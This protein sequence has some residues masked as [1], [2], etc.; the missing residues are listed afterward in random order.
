M[1]GPGAG[2]DLAQRYDDGVDSFDMYCGHT[3]QAVAVDGARL[4]QAYSRLICDGGLRRQMG[5]SARAWARGQFDWSAVLV[6]YRTLF[7]ELEERRRAD[8]ALNPALPQR[9]PDRPDPFRLFASYPSH[10]LTAASLVELKSDA[11][12][13]L[14]R[15][16]RELG[17]NRYAASSLP[18][19]EEFGLIFGAIGPRPM[20]VEELIDTLG[21]W[22]RPTLLRGLAWLCKM[23]MLK[24]TEG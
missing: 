18:T 14:V 5:E 13:A 7:D 20:Q 22:D 12:L 15:Q 23:D 4:C 1:P 17:I 3:S 24:V 21:R 10:Q 11:S 8:P 9:A 2:E 16:Y 6:R 19:L